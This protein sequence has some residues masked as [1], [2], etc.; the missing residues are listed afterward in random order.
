[1][2]QRLTWGQRP[3]A[4]WVQTAYMQQPAQGWQEVPGPALAAMAAGWRA[5]LAQA[6]VGPGDRVATLLPT[7]PALVALIPAVWNLGAALSILCPRLEGAAGASLTTATLR[8]ML[9]TLSPAVVVVP[10]TPGDDRT[11]APVIPQ[12]ARLLTCPPA[13]SLTGETA[14]ALPGET[15]EALP[16]ADP[17]GLAIVQFTSGTGGL[18][19]PVPIPHGALA[20]N[21]ATIAQRAAISPTDHYLAWL[22]LYHDLGLVSLLANLE[23]GAQCSLMDTGAFLANPFAWLTAISQRGATTSNAPASALGLM[24]RF[25]GARALKEVNLSRLR[26]ISLGGEPTAAADLEAFVA[27]FRDRG[28]D[29]LTRLTPCYGMAEAVLGVSGGTHDTAPTFVEADATL[30]RT[31]RR[32]AAPTPGT[33][34]LRL[35]ACGKPAD[36]VAVKVVDEAGQPLPEGSVG[37]LLIRGDIVAPAYLDRP[38]DLDQQGWRDTGDLG[39]L[40]QGE[41]VPAG[42]AKDVLIKGGVNHDPD[43]LEAAVLEALAPAARGVA[44]VALTSPAQSGDHVVLLVETRKAPREGFAGEAHRALLAAQGPAPDQVLCLRPGSLPRTTSGKV[45]RAVIRQTLSGG[46]PDP[47]LWPSE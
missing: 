31:E 10:A 40:W 20:R 42:R 3:P 46:A 45:Q 1:M 11:Y 24:A 2:S 29:S 18:P 44:L 19:K 39:L 22:P 33:D 13:P 27:A 16:V 15:A 43:P 26:G 23:G 37:R 32:V 36:G 5:V 47:W 34:P 12:G 38:S 9:S 41:V 4:Q 30:W 17:D 25:A 6:G 7:S 28:F 35:V 21:I 14:E 8:T